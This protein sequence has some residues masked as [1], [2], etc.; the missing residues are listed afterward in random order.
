MKTSWVKIVLPVLCTAVMACGAGCAV[1]K[2]QVP[3]GY[4]PV[5]TKTPA[6][7]T[8]AETASTEEE[9][10]EEVE[11]IMPEFP[12][13]FTDS[14]GHE[15][16][17]QAYPEKTAVLFSSYAQIW[18]ESGGFVDVTVG[19][20]VKR[21]FASED[22]ILVNDGAGLKFDME[23]LVESEPDFVIV[24]AD[25]SSQAEACEALNEM[26]IP[27]AAFR[28][29]NMEDYLS[30]LK[31]FTDLNGRQDLYEELGIQVRG[32]INTIRKELKEDLE[33][34]GILD[35]P[36]YLFIRAGSAFNSTKAK[37][38][39]DH[40]ACVI[41]DEIGLHNIADDEELLTEELSLETILT[42]D[43]DRILIVPQGDEEAVRAYIEELFTSEGWSSINAVQDGRYCFLD[44][45]LF[46]YKPNSRYAEAYCE[47][48]DLIYGE[49]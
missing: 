45:E 26:G 35:G 9:T 41:L 24:T 47:L 18:K 48:I 31:I 44:K 20:S 28:E 19:D 49:Y 32:E 23:L 3:E 46:N 38:A 29:E 34:R 40:F 13:T 12:F 16:T 7:T 25:F 11:N 10:S 8:T 14:V 36:S 39:E 2:A 6:E 4:S 21:G 15:I 42:K 33:K 5:L 27:C 37:T 22:A 30:I 43:P 1:K 17:L